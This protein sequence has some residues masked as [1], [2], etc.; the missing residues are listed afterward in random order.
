MPRILLHALLSLV[1][2][3]LT[4]EV[5]L[6]FAGLDETP[7]SA[8]LPFESWIAQ[9]SQ[10]LHTCV[11]TLGVPLV[12]LTVLAFMFSE[13]TGGGAVRSAPAEPEAPDLHRL[14]RP[15]RKVREWLQGQQLPHAATR[16][17][18]SISDHLESIAQALKTHERAETTAT[19]DSLS[20]LLTEELP[21]LVRRYQRVPR[22][23][24]LVPSVGSTTTDLLLSGLRI[25][26]TKLQD[27]L[28]SLG[29]RSVQELAVQARYLELK[30]DGETAPRGEPLTSIFDRDALIALGLPAEASDKP[31]SLVAPSRPCRHPH[32]PTAHLY[33]SQTARSA[34]AEDHEDHDKSRQP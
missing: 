2:F 19:V 15:I 24:R 29:D 25:I 27:I 23:L 9:F 14:P 22:M 34:T 17:G 6:R 31:G 7:P 12:V 28:R 20:K 33:N 3:S 26:D 18:A 16:I 8:G 4:A 32:S 13:E 1:F 11:L 10:G 5:L 21:A 30:Y